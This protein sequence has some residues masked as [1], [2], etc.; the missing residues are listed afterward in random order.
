MKLLKKHKDLLKQ[1]VGDR[2]ENCK[3]DKKELHI[4]RIKRGYA[5]GEYIPRN[6]MVICSDCHQAFH[7]GGVSED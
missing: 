4:H 3:D 7:W 5:G 1:M 2:C 6:I